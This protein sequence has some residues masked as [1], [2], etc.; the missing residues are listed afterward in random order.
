MS[1]IS[2]VFRPDRHG[3]RDG[4]RSTNSSTAWRRTLV[5]ATTLGTA[6]AG[7]MLVP[8]PATAAADSVPTVISGVVVDA[9]GRPMANIG[10]GSSSGGEEVRTDADGHFNLA[11]PQDS[12]GLRLSRSRGEAF[13]DYTWFDTEAFPSTGSHDVG[14]VRLPALVEK[15]VKIVDANGTPVANA[16]VYRGPNDPFR[17]PAWL[18]GGSAAFGD[19]HYQAAGH[20]LEQ[21]TDSAGEVHV[22]VP[23]L[24]TDP[25]YTSQTPSGLPIYGIEYTD[26]VTGV[27]FLTDTSRSTI[28]G[29]TYTT[30]LPAVVHLTGVVVDAW[31]R[32]LANIGVGSNR[33]GEQVRTDADGRFNVAVPQDSDGLQMSRSGGEAFTDYTWFETEAFP[34]TESHDVGTIRFPQLIEKTVKIVDA[35]GTPVTNASVYRSPSNPS[36]RSPDWLDG[37]STAFGDVHYQAARHRIS[38][39]TDSAGE[40]HVLIPRLNTDPDY[41]SLTPSGLP[42]YTIE[43]ND[44]VTGQFVTDTSRSTVHGNTHTTTLPDLVLHVPD[45]PTGVSATR[46][47]RSALVSWAQPSDNGSPVT[48]YTIT[49]TPGGITKTVT[50]P[51]TTSA[52]LAGL[53]NGTGYTFTVR[54][55]NAVGDSAASSPTNSVT[56]AG[57][58][59]A[60]SGVSA[61]RG[62]K[63]ATVSWA[64]PSGNGSPVTGYTITSTPGGITK[65]VDRRRH[66]HR[67][68][69]PA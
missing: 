64:K 55:T 3:S 48:G 22:L 44:P 19:V 39:H 17:S 36:F 42:I 54:A 12:Q 9:G 57:V 53:T 16:Q 13:T 58:P 50:G 47:D 25:D 5:L 40:V 49:S 2:R 51:D 63:S 15:T 52:T 30:A 29:N 66:H 18:D 43:Y 56:P 1:G 14:I 23:R 27:R 38:L 65:T 67:H 60:P 26:P 45:A 11:V 62:D 4:S 33:Y 32:P 28:D 20:R 41:T 46:G 21:R 69:R 7:L 34:A 61:L 31:G 68:H 35:N 10:V 24:N 6:L 37:G 59:D 8:S